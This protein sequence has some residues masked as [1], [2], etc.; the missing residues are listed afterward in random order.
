VSM[1]TLHFLFP[2][3]QRDEKEKNTASGIQGTQR[4]AQSVSRVKEVNFF[5][6]SLPFVLSPLTSA[7]FYSL[8]FMSL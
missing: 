2:K 5:A 6:F 7:K 3:S 8:Y 4:K 1:L